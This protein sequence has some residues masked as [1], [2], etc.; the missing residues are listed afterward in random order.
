M[1]TFDFSRFFLK[2]N[3]L[4]TV[5]YR[6]SL[7][8]FLIVLVFV[9]G[10]LLSISYS[11]ILGLKL[12]ETNSSPNPFQDLVGKGSADLPDIEPLGQ[13]GSGGHN[14]MTITHLESPYK[15]IKKNILAQE[16]KCNTD[17]ILLIKSSSGAPSCVKYDTSKKLIKRGWGI[18]PQNSIFSNIGDAKAIVT[19]IKANCSLDY[20]CGID[21]FGKVSNYLDEQIFF[22][23]VGDLISLYEARYPSCHAPAHHLG[24]VVSEFVGEDLHKAL[25]NADPRC[26]GAVTHG[27]MQNH[28][29]KIEKTELESMDIKDFC[30][31]L[32]KGPQIREEW[33]CI[34]AL[35]HGLVIS[36]DYDIFPVIQNC[37]KLDFEW[38]TESCSRG[39]FMENTNQFFDE[40]GELLVDKENFFYPCN[41]VDSEYAPSCYIYHTTMIAKKNSGN[42]ELSFMDCDSIEPEEFVKYC[43][44]GM[45]RLLSSSSILNLE[46]A[47][48]QCGL[49]QQKYQSQC[50]IAIVSI[51][52]DQ[53]GIE[54]GIE[55]CKSFSTEHK[56]ECYDVIG[57]W[58]I[59]LAEDER[60]KEELCSN[61]EENYFDV[62]MNA[63]LWKYI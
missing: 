9:S 23:T 6:F 35:G 15:Q 24:M 51:E 37:G 22:Q 12:L 3:R 16:V 58:A 62:C 26:G 5:R 49:G 32:D 45:G 43:Y 63:E 46:Y 33:E 55:I 40:K 59:L 21:T 53:K 18:L 13:M 54:R 2:K 52:T 11:E 31:T 57:K 41:E 42:L 30:N 44:I 27:I 10:S 60:H 20:N 56:D 4:S 34:H 25:S 19:Q 47:I 1:N 39:A 48:D 28:F 17:L 61:V 8:I 38:Q 14:K 7:L 36:Y 50:L 29:S